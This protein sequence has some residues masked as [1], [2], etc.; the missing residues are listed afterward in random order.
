MSGNYPT[1]PGFRSIGFSTKNF[2]LSSQ[3]ISGRMQVRRIGS[4]R[5][6]FSAQYPPMTASEFQPVMAFIA[7]QDGMAD[8]FQ[9][10]LPDISYSA[11]NAT[12]TVRVNNVG[13]YAVGSGIISVDGLNGTIKAGDVIKFS[14]HSKVYM[15]TSD[16]TGSSGNASLQITPN[17]K[18][19][20]ID[21]AIVIYNAVPFTVRLNN[22]VQQ[23]TVGVTGL[24][25][26]EVDFIEAI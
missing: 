12:G 4:S 17:L 15:L 14:N 26:F 22:D 21:D 9:I 8:T 18:E 16:A 11:G 19:A 23:F 10:T 24:R 5:F 2:N 6:E 7:S 25:Q 13:G 20:I 1:S 3:T